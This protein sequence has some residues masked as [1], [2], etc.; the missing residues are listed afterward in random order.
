MTAPTSGP[1]STPPGPQWHEGGPG[2]A[3]AW[4][5][6]AAWDCTAATVA[7]GFADLHRDA[8]AVLTDWLAP[9][10][11]SERLRTTYLHHLR[12]Y[13]DGVAKA[14]PPTHL[15]VGCLVL[16]PSGRHVLLTHHAKTGAWY[17]FGG[18]LE[19]GDRCLRAA[20]ARELAE[21][22]GLRGLELSA[23]PVHLDRHDLPQSYGRCRT[24][25][26]VRYAA[27]PRPTRRRP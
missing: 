27:S 7:R 3:D 17:Q 24:H 2:H 8:V 22:S 10:P 25:L 6:D 26:D 13:P 5:E 15:T 4:R 18:H 12:A 14:G 9:D 11:D 23:E 19:A 1:A 21:E 16:D 20:A